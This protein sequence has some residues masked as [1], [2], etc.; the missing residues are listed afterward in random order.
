MYNE[1][2]DTFNNTLQDR[3]NQRANCSN[4]EPIV[5][6]NPY[7]VSELTY[8]QSQLFR[9]KTRDLS[10][11]PGTMMLHNDSD[12]GTYFTFLSHIRQTIYNTSSLEVTGRRQ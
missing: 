7:F 8:T 6:S 11:M 12:Y 5:S 4:G 9:R 2:N 10:M 3:P 1:K